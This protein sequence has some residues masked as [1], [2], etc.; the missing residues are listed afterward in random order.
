MLALSVAELAEQLADAGTLGANLGVG[1]LESLLGIQ[2]PLLPARL[3]LCVTAGRVMPALAVGAGDGG[4]DQVA[5]SRVVVKEGARDRGAGGDG[6]VGH[7]EPAP[8]ELADGVGHAP[9]LFLSALPPGLV[10]CGY[11][12]RRPG[13]T[14]SFHPVCCCSSPVAARSA[15]RNDRLHNRW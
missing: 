6:R 14:H 12:L 13:G 3:R 15:A 8:L 1:G 4:G 2:R 5:G 9:Q 10:G 11:L 7:R